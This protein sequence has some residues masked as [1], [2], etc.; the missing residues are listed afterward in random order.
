MR[1]DALLFTSGGTKDK[2]VD[3]R[4]D[5]M[6]NQFPKDNAMG[7]GMEKISSSSN[8]FKETYEQVAQSNSA[9][10][11]T[12][13]A[14]DRNNS[15]QR[16]FFPDKKV[17]KHGKTDYHKSNNTIA[18]AQTND[19]DRRQ[20]QND[21]GNDARVD[22]SEDV[23]NN[24]DCQNGRNRDEQ[25]SEII[26]QALFDIS[27]ALQLKIVPG[28]EQ[29]SFNSGSDETVEQLT[30]IVHDLKTIINALDM[31]V[32]QDQSIDTGK[33]VVDSK[34]AEKLLTTLKGELFKIE[35]GI[36]M[37][38]KSEDVQ[39]QLSQKMDSP[40][41]YGIPQATDPAQ[42]SMSSEQ[43]RKL[44]SEVFSKNEDGSNVSQLV[45]KLN[46]LVKENLSD[47]TSVKIQP[48]LDE[49]STIS[50]VTPFNAQTFRAMLKIEMKE[51]V[52]EENMDAAE[53]SGKLSL[54]ES[55]NGVLVKDPAADPH[56]LSEQVLSVTEIAA[57]THQNQNSVLQE[58]RTPVNLTKTL[59]Q[60]V[61]NQITDKLN[62][63]VR[64]GITEVRVQLRPEALGEVTL[65]IR[66]E[67]DVVTA[68]MQVENHQVK[69]IVENNFQSLKD[70]L[71]QHNLQTG[72]LEVNVQTGERHQDT[73]GEGFF[74]NDPQH[75]TVTSQRS[76]IDES[77]V[78]LTDEIAQMETGRR[79][80]NNT[81]EYFA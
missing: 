54:P 53:K 8:R 14:A 45:N 24:E 42:L 7:F 9:A 2:P 6:L 39:N 27:D 30:Q 15:C 66:I 12:D 60:S 67:G 59:E 68:K 80:G 72:S 4:M 47:N 79:F 38:G 51:K 25:A 49:K 5:R 11:Q 74:N 73:P 20:I 70:S 10:K 1:T 29:V 43:T 33:Q 62:T 71:S 16:N 78:A 3:N 76:D 64:S 22:D 46:D 55:A 52:S 21:S 58:I 69:A 48:V 36:N 31:A 63:A 50:D 37:L 35:I 17:A 28:L 32:S 41:P 44:F 34:D 81:I 56:K 18:K 13:K 61:V 57:K 75:H 65:K 19:N 23:S 40:F 26:T 77:D